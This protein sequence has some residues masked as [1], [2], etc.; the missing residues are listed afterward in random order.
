VH[1]EVQEAVVGVV[2]DPLVLVGDRGFG[3][4]ATNG[5][6]RVAVGGGEGP[7]ADVRIDDVPA[8][9]KLTHPPL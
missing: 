1:F 8:A 6:V 4:P 5:D 9:L 7:E 2:L 3:C